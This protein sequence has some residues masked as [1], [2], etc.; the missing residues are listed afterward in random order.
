M[1]NRGIDRIIKPETE[2]GIPSKIPRHFFFYWSGQDFQY[3]NYLC[4]L[5]L[6]KTNR[7]QRCEIY[8]EEEPINNRNW[9]ELKRLGKVKLVR[10][11]YDELFKA[12]GIRKEDFNEFFDKAK[13]N[14]KSNLFRY[15]I[16]YRYGGIYIDFDMIIIRD[17]EPLLNTGLFVGFQ[18][19]TSRFSRFRDSINGAIM[20]SVEKSPIL[21]MC[22]ERVKKLSKGVEKFS[23]AIMGPFL[24]TKL[25]YPKSIFAKTILRIIEYLDRSNWDKGGLFILLHRLIQDKKLDFKIYPKSFFYFYAGD[26]WEKIFQKKPLPCNSYLIHLWQ[27]HSRKFTSKIDKVYIKSKDSLYCNIANKFIEG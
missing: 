4:V 10:L 5:S 21:A 26:E 17:L 9:D 15:I 12:C 23:W 6:L 19:Y 20:G 22:L 7:I 2:N 18:G 13:T 14:H 1:L 27:R 11:N 8:Y 16:L 25:L 24:L 3:V